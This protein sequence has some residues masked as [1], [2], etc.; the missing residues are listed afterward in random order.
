M[1]YLSA[2]FDKNDKVEM[3]IG[4]GI[5]ITEMKRAERYL[6]KYAVELKRSNQDLEQFA[7]LASHD[8]KTPLRVV[9]SFLQL[10][11]RRNKDKFDNTDFEY[12]GYAKD[13][14]KNLSIMIEDLL[15]YARIDKNLD[16]PKL[17]E[18]TDIIQFLHNNIK[19]Y[20]EE[21]NANIII[22]QSISITAHFTLIYQLINN[23]VINGIKYNQSK[24]PTIWITAQEI[25]D[26][27]IIII[28]DN[29]IGI[30]KDFQNTIFQMFTRI[31]GSIYEGTGIGLA[32]CKR[33]VEYYKGS[34]EINSEV[35]HGSA[36]QINFPKISIN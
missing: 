29:G 35:G 24:N 4:Y 9:H 36:F 28:R 5:D 14:V 20:I 16:R 30:E 15:Q 6:K 17:I 21:R 11:E 18:L 13:N 26:M 12:L 34:I 27:V 31:N 1:R 23:L 32:L 22:E 3:V 10:L 19:T 7:H 33:I 2:I 8:L 25:N